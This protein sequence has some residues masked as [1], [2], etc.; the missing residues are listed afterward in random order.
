M[1]LTVQKRE[2]FGRKLKELRKQDL[3]PAELYGREID[4]IH[5]SVPAKN[6]KKIF[7]EAGESSVI[8]IV[9]EGEKRPVLIYNIHRHPVTDAIL[10]VDFY[11]V[12]MDEKV[13]A[14]VPIEFVGEA[15]A[16]KEGGVLLKVVQEI[17]VEALPADMPRSIEIDLDRLVEV[18]QSI[19]VKDISISNNVKILAEPDSVIVT[20]KP[21]V[22]EEEEKALEEETTGIE[23]IE[24]EGED[25]AKEGEEEGESPP[26]GGGESE[27]GS[28]EENKKE[29]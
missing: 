18:D 14:N 7:K 25:K 29:E 8:D 16:V 11:Q 2:V 1:E 28:K 22:T 15:P 9:I 19:Y 3:I 13:Q 10:S 17:E 5:L 20:I 6:F 24:V 4:N 23:G 27:E 21:Q 12:K 26:V